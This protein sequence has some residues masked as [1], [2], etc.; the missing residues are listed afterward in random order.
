MNNI[1][2]NFEPHTHSNFSDGK[3]TLE[4][5][6]LSA[7][8]KG[9]A[10]IALTDH[11]PKHMTYGVTKRRLDTY[12]KEANRLKTAY[13][14][15]IDV[16]VGMEFNILNLDGNIDMPQGYESEFEWSALGLHK[17]VRY[18]NIQSELNLIIYQFS[19]KKRYSPAVIEKNTQAYITAISK[20]NIDMLAHLSYATKVDVERIA[21]VCETTNTLIELNGKHVEFDADD[22]KAVLNTNANFILGSDAHKP[23]AI[24]TCKRGKSFVIEN[25][26]P[27]NRVINAYL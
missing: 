23:S 18:S 6:V 16:L 7:I 27:L 9:I 8:N 5:N 2:M 1:K 12:L 15:D 22:A 10:K 3:S 14:S 24:G 26:I 4:E 20:Y 11:G 17:L 25:N 21:K 13:K 19:E